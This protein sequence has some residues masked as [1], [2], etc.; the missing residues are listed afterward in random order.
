[1]KTYT[2]ANVYDGLGYDCIVIVVRIDGAHAW[3]SWVQHGGDHSGFMR[4]VPAG[5]LRNVR[6]MDLLA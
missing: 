1:M 5:A 3:V 6:E 2:V 4:R